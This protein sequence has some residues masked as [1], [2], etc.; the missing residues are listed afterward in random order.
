MVDRIFA[1]MPRSNVWPGDSAEPPPTAP[2]LFDREPDL[3][4]R[5][6]GYA[7]RPEDRVAAERVKEPS[8]AAPVMLG[9]WDGEA[10]VEPAV[11]SGP[12]AA[13]ELDAGRTALVAGALDQAAL[14]FGLALRAAPALAPAVLEATEGARSAG[15]SMVRGDAYRLAGHETSARQ[16]YAVA[17]Q[18]GPPE[19]RARARKKAD[20]TAVNPVAEVPI[21]LDDEPGASPS[22]GVVA[23][24]TLEL[25]R[26]EAA[27]PAHNAET[28][29]SAEPAEA[30]EPEEPSGEV[31][32]PPAGTAETVSD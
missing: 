31:A 27:D 16:A 14:H 12:D 26:A 30:S 21:G 29:D 2:T 1:G 25:D 19:R 24:P 18:G 28:A 10:D 6:D 4:P 23:A 32:D 7:P 22:Q 9:F 20:L 11:M 3:P 5:V 8:T 15:L 13:A 17:A